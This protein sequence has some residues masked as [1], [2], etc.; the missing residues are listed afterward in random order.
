MPRPDGPTLVAVGVGEPATAQ[1]AQVRDAAAAFGRASNRYGRLAV[2]L[3]RLPDIPAADAAQAAVEGV[4]LARY[5]YDVLRN[6]KREI[7]LTSLTLVA[8]ASDA[9]AVRAGSERGRTLAAAGALA[10]DLANTPPAYLSA[11]RLAE[12]GEALGPQCGLAIEI[13]DNDALEAIGC[14]GLL[15]V[16]R[17]STEPARLIVMHY[18]PEDDA[19]PAGRL[20]LVGKGVMYDSGGIS[21]KPSNPVHATMKTDMSGA[22]AVFAAMT[23]L[24][25]LEVASAVTAWL[26]CTD[27]MPDGS[28]MALGDILTVRGG[29]TVEV[30]NTDAEGRLAMADALVLAV[31][32]HVDA[33]VDVATL[34]GACVV[35]L[36]PMTAG[37]FGNNA[38]LVGQVE[39]AA[40]LSDE[41][42]WELP[43][44]RRYRPWMD[45]DTADIKNLGGD[46]AGA[47]TAAL[48][49]EEFVAAT[50]WAHI[51]IAGTAMVNADDSWRAQGGSGFGA[52]LLAEL[53]VN[54]AP[55]RS[56]A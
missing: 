29:K 3:R 50:P 5:R 24:R 41:P 34:I 12:L 46:S 37:L 39:A 38:D 31:E 45:S 19:T 23:A 14:G 51:D 9:D 13:F 2:D 20:G 48:F 43:L 1:T 27:N 17:G 28:A 33:I 49:L 44:V 16:N 21:L 36:G 11:R 35:A 4:L 53:A 18:R 10:R 25:E 7:P 32:D 55:P 6:E 40:Q 15:G 42:V 22:G 30:M 54:F 47:I 52:R 26:V 56:I 8:D